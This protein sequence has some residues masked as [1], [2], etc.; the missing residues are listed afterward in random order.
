MP[1]LTLKTY[2]FIRAKSNIYIKTCQDKI[3]TNPNKKT[4]LSTKHTLISLQKEQEILTFLK[5]VLRFEK[6]EQ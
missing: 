3:S 5:K 2:F 4:T 6:N 1:K